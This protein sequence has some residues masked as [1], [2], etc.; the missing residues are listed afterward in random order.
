MIPE[1]QFEHIISANN[2]LQSAYARMLKARQCGNPQE[3]NHA[4]LRYLQVLQVAYQ[5]AENAV[6]ADFGSDSDERSKSRNVLF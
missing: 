4:T 1:H 5:T 6:A 3:I 2:A